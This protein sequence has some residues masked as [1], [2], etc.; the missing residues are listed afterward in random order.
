M[1]FELDTTAFT[2]AK[3][4]IPKLLQILRQYRSTRQTEID[5]IADDFGDPLQLAEYYVEPDCQQFNPADDDEDEAR[6]F[7]REP[8]FSRLR[9]FF[10]GHL[11]TGGHQMFILA[12]S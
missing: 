3:D 5:Y 9:H 11:L 2:L 12:D 7:V 6:Y 8:I 10:G 1:P 4:W